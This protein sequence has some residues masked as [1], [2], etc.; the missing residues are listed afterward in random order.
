MGFASSDV[1]F[2]TASLPYI[3]GRLRIADKKTCSERIFV[4]ARL[5]PAQ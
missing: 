1:V 5:D 4:S 2:V 3:V